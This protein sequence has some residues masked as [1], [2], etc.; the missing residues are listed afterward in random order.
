MLGSRI[1]HITY[2]L[3]SDIEDIITWDERLG[4]DYQKIGHFLSLQG[5]WKMRSWIEMFVDCF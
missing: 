5:E 1:S 2:S 3:K 4:N